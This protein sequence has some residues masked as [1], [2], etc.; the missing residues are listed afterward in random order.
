MDDS[1][2]PGAPARL[3]VGAALVDSLSW[4]RLLLAAR[5]SAPPALAGRWEFPGGKVDRGET[6]EQALRRELDE[7]LG[8]QVLLGAEVVAGV[9]VDDPDHG[10]VWPLGAGFVL[11][12][13]LAQMVEPSAPGL[14]EPREDHDALRWLGAQELGSVPWL[15]ADAEAVLA[16]SRRMLRA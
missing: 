12:L 1:D 11:R 16:V 5:R 2:R 7:E 10:R 8:V 9:G 15:A 3:V 6:P 13:W 14:P 4:P